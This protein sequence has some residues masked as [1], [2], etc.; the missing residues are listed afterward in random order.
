MVAP[1]IATKKRTKRMRDDNDNDK[2]KD[3][4]PQPPANEGR[5]TVKGHPNYAVDEDEHETSHF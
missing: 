3:D 1:S 4:L 5:G 2:E